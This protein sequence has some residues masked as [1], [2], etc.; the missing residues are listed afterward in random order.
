MQ[1]VPKYENKIDYIVNL[2]KDFKNINILELGVR[3]GISTKKFLEICNQNNGKL[4]SIDIDDCSKVSN[5]KRWTFIHSSDD[6]FEIVDKEINS[7][8]DL[9]YIDSYHEPNHVEK[10]F[11]H[12]YNYL[13][14]GGICVIDDISWL[15]Y[16]KNEYRDNE[17]SEMINKSIFK[18]ILEIYNQNKDKFLLEFY[19]EGSGLAII[20][21]KKDVL[22][23][24][25]RILSRDFSVKNILRVIFNRKPKK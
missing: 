9:I 1:Y 23:E 10:V 19:F 8:L 17:Y 21:K 14:I 24:S 20:R 16:C 11:N 6:N 22:N 13:K 12:Y 25:K 18:K 4:V 15:P 7:K 2:V 3:E 5:D